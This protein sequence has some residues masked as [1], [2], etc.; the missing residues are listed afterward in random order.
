MPS[1]YWFFV[2]KLQFLTI[3]RYLGPMELRRITRIWLV[4]QNLIC[5]AVNRVTDYTYS[6]IFVIFNSFFFFWQKQE[7]N[8]IFS[9]FWFG[10]CCMHNVISLYSP[11]N[12]DEWRCR[13]T[14]RM[15]FFS[16]QILQNFI[17]WRSL[18]CNYCFTT[19]HLYVHLSVSFSSDL[20]RI[21][22]QMVTIKSY[23]IGFVLN[24][25]PGNC[26][27]TRFTSSKLK[28]AKKFVGASFMRIVLIEYG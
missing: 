1:N 7:L 11:T 4:E 21:F 5:S 20:G 28:L 14:F 18:I 22:I 6:A 9:S 27:D 8:A 16:R 2:Q 19:G 23:I 13:N 3:W 15:Q 17:S 12:Q 10:S 24:Y 26:S 25:C